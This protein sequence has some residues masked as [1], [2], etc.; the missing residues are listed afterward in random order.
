MFDRIAPRYDLMNRLMTGYQDQRWRRTAARIAVGSGADRV[1]DAA[2]GTGDLARALHDAGAREVVGVDV[3]SAMLERAASNLRRCPGVRVLYA[4]V[5]ELPFDDGS[6]DACTIGFGLRNLPDYQAGIAE[7]ARV[8]A[9][10]GRLVILELTP[11]ADSLFRTLFRPYFERIVPAL[12]GLIAGDRA[13]YRYLPESVHNFP[14]AAKLA[15]MMHAAGLVDIRWRYAGVGSVA[16]H[17][18]TKPE[19]A[20]W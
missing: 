18:G 6:F 4:D 16:L 1:L 8:L 15:G 13:A 9:P 3:S 17:V 19:G 2:T 12:G 10:G 14:D 7:M 5:M 11:Q 20:G